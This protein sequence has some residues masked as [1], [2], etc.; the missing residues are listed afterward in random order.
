[1]LDYA[2]IR[3]AFGNSFARGSFNRSR[4][5]K[6]TFVAFNHARCIW[7]SCAAAGKN[8]VD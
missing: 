7:S 8:I 6:N 1:M 3:I 4:A 2:I 5:H